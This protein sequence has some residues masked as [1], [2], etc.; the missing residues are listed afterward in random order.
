MSNKN[1][2]FD[3]DS[4]KQIINIQSNQ[5][6]S[7]YI[8]QKDV[9][10]CTNLSKKAFNQELEPCLFRKKAAFQYKK[11]KEDLNYNIGKKRKN[12]YDRS[13]NVRENQKRQDNSLSILTRRFMKQIRSEQNQTIDL[14]QVS[15]VLGV[16]KRRIYDITNVLEGIN[17]VKKVSKNK[18]KWIGPP[19]QEAKE[20]RIIA[21]VQQLIAEEMI[22]DKVIYEFNEKIQNLLQQKEDFC[23]FNRMDIQQLGKNQKPNEKTIVIQL[24]KKSIIQI[25][26]FQKEQKEIKSNMEILKGNQKFESLKRICITS[27]SIGKFQ[28]GNTQYQ[29]PKKDNNQIK[30]YQISQISKDQ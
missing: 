20:N 5:N 3:K 7:Q 10:Q 22:L 16:Q 23:Y 8:N 30:V 14:N 28:K 1:L 11:S 19:N 17:Y 21:E 9:H 26:D 24:P 6:D 15:I 12:V 27:T 4:L 18:L 25:K 2:Q 29:S 13:I